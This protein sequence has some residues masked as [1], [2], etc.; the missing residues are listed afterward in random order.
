MTDNLRRND[1]RLEPVQI[2]PASSLSLP[3]V[4][5][6]PKFEKDEGTTFLNRKRK[7]TTPQKSVR[8]RTIGAKKRRNNIRS[9]GNRNLLQEEAPELG[10]LKGDFNWN[11]IF[12]EVF[13]ATEA[14][15]SVTP[16]SLA[17]RPSTNEGNESR[18]ITSR[19]T[20]DVTNGTLLALDM[21]SLPDIPEPEINDENHDTPSALLDANKETSW[22]IK[23]ESRNIYPEEKMHVTTKPF[24]LPISKQI[25]LPTLEDCDLFFPESN[26]PE[27][28]S[29]NIDDIDLTIT[30]K[31]I[32]PPE[33]WIPVSPDLEAI[34]CETQNDEVLLQ[35][36]SDTLDVDRLLMFNPSPQ[37][38]N[39]DQYLSSVEIIKKRKQKS[40]KTDPVQDNNNS[41]I[42][43]NSPFKNQ[44]TTWQQNHLTSFN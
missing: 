44:Q 7:Q 12:D 33:E 42:D 16:T 11:T 14:A 24:P 32:A 23:S 17:S 31:Q 5:H 9:A 10:S 18:E 21:L 25:E 22:Q 20:D 2:S 34:L 19:L 43:Q 41:I 39:P 1:P 15:L 8:R 26:E 37:N 35:H 40:R 36:P 4:P 29:L 6:L 30:G 38:N 28:D 27:M 13:G 3:T